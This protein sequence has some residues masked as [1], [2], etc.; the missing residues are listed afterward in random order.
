LPAKSIC[1]GGQMKRVAQSRTPSTVAMPLV[2]W[3]R[4]ATN[5]F[6]GTGTFL[7]TKGTASPGPATLYL[8]RIPW[9]LAVAG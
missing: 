2:D 8:I 7:F 6:S 3:D 1:D 5:L 9:R 4:V